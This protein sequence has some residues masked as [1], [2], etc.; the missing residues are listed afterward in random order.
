MAIPV[1]G[2]N[3]LKTLFR[4]DTPAGKAFKYGID[5]PTENT[6]TTLDLLGYD[7]AAAG[8]QSLVDAPENYESA[9]ARF[10]NLEG[11]GYNWKDLPLATVEQSGQLAGSMGLRAAGAG[12]GT[13]VGSPVLGAILAFGGPALFEAIQI[14]GPVAL[15]RAKNNGREEP[16]EE[17]WA[18][19]MG[20]AGF[21]G[22]LNAIGVKGIPGLNSAVLGTTGKTIAQT[23]AAGLRE[24]VTEGL[25]GV[26]EQV[27]GTAL[28]DKG[29]T[30]N[31]KQAIGEGLIGGTTGMVATG[32]AA[33]AQAVNSMS[34]TVDPTISSLIDS[35]ASASDTLTADTVDT[36]QPLLL[37]LGEDQ[38]ISETAMASVPQSETYQDFNILDP[39]L[40]VPEDLSQAKELFTREDVWPRLPT[41]L[42]ESIYSESRY[43]ETASELFSYLEGPIE[44]DLKTLSSVKKTNKIWGEELG[45]D[46]I[47]DY[48][49]NQE[50]IQ[51]NIITE[52]PGFKDKVKKEFLKE[53]FNLGDDRA[54][55]TTGLL[56][57]DYGN[58]T[59]GNHHRLIRATNRVQYNEVASKYIAPFMQEQLNLIVAPEYQDLMVND[60]T[61]EF[62]KNLLLRSKFDTNNP[63]FQALVKKV[64]GS[65]NSFTINS[66]GQL[67]ALTKEGQTDLRNSVQSLDQD[68][69][70][71]TKGKL[72][73]AF[74]YPY[75]QRDLSTE[76]AFATYINDLEQESF[77]TELQNNN[78]FQEILEEAPRFSYGIPKEFTPR[79][80][81]R[82]EKQFYGE[83]KDHSEIYRSEEDPSKANFNESHD[84]MRSLL[85][86]MAKAKEKIS[87]SSGLPKDVSER[88]SGHSK[89]KPLNE[90]EGPDTSVPVG[91]SIGPLPSFI[92]PRE[93][94]ATAENGP[95]DPNFLTY[96]LS[97]SHLDKLRNKGIASLS[98]SEMLTYLSTPYKKLPENLKE[99]SEAVPKKQ[100]GEDAQDTAERINEIRDSSVR[101][102]LESQGELPVSIEYIQ[103]LIDDNA[104]RF[105]ISEA[106]SWEDDELRHGSD[107]RISGPTEGY[108]EYTVNHIPLLK[109]EEQ[110]IVDSNDIKA[111]KKI[112]EDSPHVYT[113]RDGTH[114]WSSN[115]WNLR[116]LGT[117]GWMRGS[118]RK[119]GDNKIGAL[120]GESQSYWIQQTRKAMSKAKKGN[121]SPTKIFRSDFQEQQELDIQNASQ[122]ELEQLLFEYEGMLPEVENEFATVLATIG[123]EKTN[124]YPEGYFTAFLNNPGT[125]KKLLQN[126]LRDINRLYTEDQ[127]VSTYDRSVYQIIA[128]APNFEQDSK[129]IIQTENLKIAEAF[130][131]EIF[132]M[133]PFKL[134]DGTSFTK[135][136]IKERLESKL[137]TQD[138]I[139]DKYELI[140]TVNDLNPEINL[141]TSQVEIETA[142]DKIGEVAS[143]L[144]DNESVRDKML[145]MQ[146]NSLE[147]ALQSS[148]VIQDY[149][150]VLKVLPDETTI[151]EFKNSLEMGDA[152]IQPD[153]PFRNKFNQMNL[154]AWI[155]QSMKDGLEFVLIPATKNGKEY[156]TVTQEQYGQG[157]A[158]MGNYVSMLKEGEKIAKEYGLPIQTVTID[159]GGGKTGEVTAID[160]RALYEIVTE[161]GF[162][163]GYKKG[164]LVTKAQG[165]GYSMNLGN[166]GR[167]YK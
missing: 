89:L 93:E 104:S 144:I 15:E 100:Q 160:I 18:G 77:N 23:T 166:Y 38:T 20:T 31:P 36:I 158:P 126:T 137:R 148:P 33:V 97:R 134:I 159:V 127:I 19:A 58:K 136:K 30:I 67:N 41:S 16:N 105:S 94:L 54:E 24:G 143:R 128:S 2:Q 5:Q 1:G 46:D 156:L 119:F 110:M 65:I 76:G 25:Q 162:K 131:E 122:P 138:K 34:S 3:F 87:I 91:A 4:S 157:S 39:I 102:Y 42:R 80:I 27:G 163:G 117:V 44:K 90:A 26:T 73:Q 61:K 43:K 98:G 68:I 69:N 133:Q 124:Q 49:P 32:P 81:K 149:F 37:P 164:G 52:D 7:D 95:L 101:P 123:G 29:L 150:D 6:A 75:A 161:G 96:S 115:K 21:S 130:A 50:F 120:L 53:Q 165:A 12:V 106:R 35:S 109:P 113:E 108:A 28:T 70:D 72:F 51:K 99:I 141:F 125:K 64:M 10:M 152:V 63:E 92:A 60:T 142:F 40:S 151:R 45:S 13:L 107:Y 121:F 9:A 83:I 86:N 57:S 129:N 112:L 47:D 135:Q 145:N 78:F 140:Q 111:G 71:L 147:K 114:N 11:E 153:P 146:K 79:D 55:N 116:G 56:T 118:L 14:A 59:W 17:D 88:F 155:V 74:A 167:N 154:R 8:L 82:L 62:A 84:L 48:K 22:V 132:Q 85:Q 66:S 139:F 103:K